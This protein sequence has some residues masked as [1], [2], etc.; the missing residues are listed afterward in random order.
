MASTGGQLRGL[1]VL[2]THVLQQV[3]TC[4]ADMNT[5]STCV[6]KHAGSARP[7]PVGR[8][9]QHS[10]QMDWTHAAARLQ[11][12]HSRRLSTAPRAPARGW[13]SG[14]TARHAALQPGWDLYCRKSCTPCGHEYEASSPPV[15]VRPDWR[16]V[17]KL[18]RLRTSRAPPQGRAPCT[19]SVQ[20]SRHNQQQCGF[21]HKCQSSPGKFT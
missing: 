16:S 19:S 4:A 8:L 15:I 17:P 18:A 3:G 2:C 7:A 12:A 6:D 11:S 9:T 5:H 14:G 21:Q 13:R 10:Q 1:G 20:R